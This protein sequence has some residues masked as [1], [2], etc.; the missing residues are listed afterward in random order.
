[1]FSTDSI[2]DIPSL[3]K[4]CGFRALTECKPHS[5][6]TERKIVP[7]NGRADV[8]VL[9][10]LYF[11]YCIGF[12]HYFGEVFFSFFEK[13][14]DKQAFHCYKTKRHC[15][16]WSMRFLLTLCDYEGPS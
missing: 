4:S 6:K 11:L 14:S 5:N 16:Y 7:I 15:S 12:M 8:A 2:C 9:A 3:W 10:E 13:A 1:M